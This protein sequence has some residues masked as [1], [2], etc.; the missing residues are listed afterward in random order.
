[1]NFIIRNLHNPCISPQNSH[2]KTIYKPQYLQIITIRCLSNLFFKTCRITN[3]GEPKIVSNFVA[4]I[5]VKTEGHNTVGHQT[6]CTQTIKSVLPQTLHQLNPRRQPVLNN[7]CSSRVA[8]VHLSKLIWVTLFPVAVQLHKPSKALRADVTC[9]LV[10]V[11]VAAL[12]V[13]LK[14]LVAAELRLTHRADKV[15]QSDHVRLRYHVLAQILDRVLIWLLQQEAIF[16]KS[17][18]ND[19]LQ[20]SRINNLLQG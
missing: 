2:T 12:N 10:E 9:K 13:R 17:S 15:G 3:T 6:R 11:K 16:C 19:P 14:R 5:S 1:M 7:R 8:T 4:Q 18:I 20:N